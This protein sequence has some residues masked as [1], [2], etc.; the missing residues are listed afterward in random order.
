MYNGLELGNVGSGCRID[1]AEHPS[2]IPGRGWFA[3][4]QRIAQSLYRDD[5]WLR[6]AAVAF[7]ALFAAIPVAAVV[8]SVVGLLADPRFVHDPFDM[9]GG[10]LPSHV[11]VFLGEQM[12]GIA[13]TSRIHLGAGLGGAA[14]AA[15]WGAWSGASGLIAALNLAYREVETRSFW[16]RSCHALLV[17]LGACVFI[18][19][20]IAVVAL[21]PLT[22]D[23]S[24]ADPALR[25]IVSVARWPALALVCALA[26][27]VL[28]KFAPSRRAAKWRWV[29]PGAGAA[30]ALWLAGS[31]IFSLY[32]SNMP[33][34]NHALGVLGMLML[35]LS[36]SYL[37]S[38][39]VLFGAELNAELERQTSQDTTTGPTRRL[40]ERGATV[41]DAK[42][43]TI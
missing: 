24:S 19:L 12:E 13:L 6:S 39:A 11:S 33:A 9:L 1:E 20:A 21:L 35:L 10:L 17:A 42:A 18:L 27:A 30:A 37:T 4:L 31:A 16:R 5:V 41:A 7:S 23:R 8:V 34:Y 3:V 38:F 32:A 2:D 40:G 25:S 26:L 28:Y 15:L 14:V 22:L 43:N 36:W 29:S